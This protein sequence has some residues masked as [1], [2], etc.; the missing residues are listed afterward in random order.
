MSAPTYQPVRMAARTVTSHRALTF[1][2]A[3]TPAYLTVTAAGLLVAV[4][5]AAAVALWWPA[6]T[7]GTQLA[8][9]LGAASSLVLVVGYLAGM[10]WTAR[11]RRNSDC[12]PG[13]EHRHARAWAWAGW[14]VPV[15]NLWVPFQVLRDVRARTLPH[16]RT[17]APTRVWWSAW[18][19]MLVSA[20]AVSQLE[21]ASLSNA[22]VADVLPAARTL[23]TVATLVAAVLWSVVVLRITAEQQAA[24]DWQES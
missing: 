5:A 22:A 12:F 13:L 11:V 20:G 4:R 10:V 19:F 6:A 21:V 17:Q 15:A 24:R 1:R 2:G 18:W 14:L 7:T 16:T 23:L 3:Q 9:D 8:E